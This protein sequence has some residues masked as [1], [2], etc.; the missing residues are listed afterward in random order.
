[1]ANGTHQH[2]AIQDGDTVILSSNPVPG[3][4]KFVYRTSTS[5]TRRARA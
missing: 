1:M 5:S 2:I 3:N 4:E